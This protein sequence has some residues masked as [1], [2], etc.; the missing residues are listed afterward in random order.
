MIEI[1]MNKYPMSLK[2]NAHATGAGEQGENL[3]CC[4]VST[5]VLT[6][7]EAIMQAGISCIHDVEEGKAIIRVTPRPAKTYE[8]DIIYQTVA[9][10]LSCLAEEYPEYIS[11]KRGDSDG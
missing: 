5:L 4:A 3:V 11:M 6:F 9:T 2:A 10:G 1:E 8:A 7:C